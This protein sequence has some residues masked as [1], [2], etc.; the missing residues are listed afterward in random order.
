ML[1]HLQGGGEDPCS[2]RGKAVIRLAK[3][4]ELAGLQNI[5]LNILADTRHESLNEINRD[6]VT[7]NFI[8]WLDNAVKHHRDVSV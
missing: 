3:R 2:A 1:F 5:S 8:S 6:E 4:L 7:T